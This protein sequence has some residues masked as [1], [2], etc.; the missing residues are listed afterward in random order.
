MSACVAADLSFYRSDLI[1]YV[2]KVLINAIAINRNITG[3]MQSPCIT[4]TV[5]LIYFFIFFNFQDGF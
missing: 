1:H 5:W 2:S 4:P 3:A